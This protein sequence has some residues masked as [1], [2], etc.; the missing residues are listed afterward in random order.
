MFTNSY[1][2]VQN[3]NWRENH[4]IQSIECKEI[5]FTQTDII[6]ILRQKIDQWY[7]IIK[8]IKQSFK[9]ILNQ[10]PLIYSI[11]KVLDSLWLWHKES[12]GALT[13][14]LS[15]ITIWTEFNV[16]GWIFLAMCNSMYLS[17]AYDKKS[18][19]RIALSLHGCIACSVYG[20]AAHEWIEV[21]VASKTA[22]IALWITSILATIKTN[23]HKEM[24]IIAPAFLAWQYMLNF[25]YTAW[26]SFFLLA[27]IAYIKLASKLEMRATHFAQIISSILV[28]YQLYQTLHNH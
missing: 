23:I 16:L 15:K 3:N 28:F 12:F 19:T 13:W 25:N 2:L 24:M 9:E 10:D 8:D 21:W 11:K 18:P 20:I 4:K 5:K 14:L 7:Q 27:H 22:I 17:I 26:W 6:E 1:I